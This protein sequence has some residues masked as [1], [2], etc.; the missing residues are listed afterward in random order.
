VTRLT[1]H[2]LPLTEKAF[3]AQVVDLATA[4]GFRH[5]HPLRMRGSDPGWP[6]L[7]LVRPPRLIFAELKVG[8]N[9]L[10]P[11]QEEWI[12]LLD[13]CYSVE[14]YIW[15]PEDFDEIVRVLSRRVGAAA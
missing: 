7:T 10:T 11:A 13:G 4:Y 3:Q 1:R 5:F 6:D 9:R 8:R 14:A 15:R 2:S 12:A